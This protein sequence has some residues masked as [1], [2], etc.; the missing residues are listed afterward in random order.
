MDGSTTDGR[1]GG[2]E[3]WLSSWWLLLLLPDSYDSRSDYLAIDREVGLVVAA[4][5][6]S[7]YNLIGGK[8]A[9]YGDRRLRLW[10]REIYTKKLRFLW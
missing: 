7:I 4:Y 3:K 8:V 2:L 6:R 5:N 1:L 10:N 9:M